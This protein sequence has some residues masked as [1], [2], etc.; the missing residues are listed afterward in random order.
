MKLKD[1]EGKTCPYCDRVWKLSKAI[2]GRIRKY[3]KTD[4][5]CLG[6]KRTFDVY[7]K[8]FVGY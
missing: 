3:G 2:E 5:T 4:V 6:C 1:K 8:E 7:K